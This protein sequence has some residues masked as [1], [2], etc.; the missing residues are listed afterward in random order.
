MLDG[1]RLLPDRLVTLGLAGLG[2]L[3]LAGGA[4]LLRLH[5]SPWYAAAGLALLGISL[6]RLRARPAAGALLVGLLLA[7]LAWSLWEAGLDAWALTPRL[8]LLAALGPACHFAA[9]HVR[10][11]YADRLAAW[12]GTLMLAGL[13]LLHWS[14]AHRELPR[15]LAADADADAGAAP[16]AAPADSEWLHYGNDP[17]GSRWS[18]LAQVDA[19]N[20]QGLVPA[21]SFRTGDLG[22][23]GEEFNFEATP[24]KAGRLLYACTPTGQA[25][26]L[27]AASGALAWRFDAHADRA[28]RH[29]FICRGVSYYAAPGAAGRCGQRIYVTDLA[30]RLWSLDALEGT[31]CEGFGEHGS[32]DLAAGLG[33]VRPDH[34]SVTSPPVVVRGLLVV[35]ARVK[36]NVSTDMPSGVVRAY[37]ALTG[38]LAWAWDVGRDATP[39]DAPQAGARNGPWTRSTPNA[40]AP[41]SADEQLGLV[42]VP[43]GNAAADFWG[44]QR[45]P[46]DERSSAAVVALDA[47]TGA[48]RWVFQTTHHDV[49]DNDISA[50]PVLA[51]WPV[52]GGTRPAVIVGTKQ[53]NLFVLDRRTGEPIVPVAEQPVPQGSELGE[54]LAPTQPHSQLSVNPGPARLAESHMWGLTPLDQMLCRIRFR[55]ARYEGPYTPPGTSRPSIIYPGMFGGIEWGSVAVDPVHRVLVANPSAMPFILRIAPAAGTAGAGAPAAE[56]TGTGLVEVQGTG[57]AASFFGFLSPLKVPCLQP[58]WGTLH[59]IDMVS[60]RPLWQRPVGTT[61]DSGPLGH[62]LG[63]ALPIGTPQVGGTLVTAGGLVFAGA[64]LDRALRAYELSSGRELWSARLPAGGQATPMTYMQAGRQYVVIAAGGHSVLGTAPGDWIVAYALPR[65]VTSP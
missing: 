30:S 40:W 17:G 20:V 61:R 47:A 65:A 32:V 45:R 26:A 34:Y 28:G 63:L 42:Y 49:W 3:L 58:P 36:D 24:L 4:W 6:L 21:W 39:R 2:A 44:R 50:Q 11:S 41:M 48:Q 56:G 22:H 12:T 64:T 54:P 5:G 25:V 31:P 53:G 33:E 46:F 35:G 7:T 62:A 59:A 27:D 16:A 57:Y 8:A 51:D 19:A 60:G 13:A 14:A 9:P 55:Q 18:P 52:P 23:P 43:T 29:T 10:R 15:W 37:D 38:R 1:L